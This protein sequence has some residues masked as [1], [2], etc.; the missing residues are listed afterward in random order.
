MT[1]VLDNLTGVAPGGRNAALNR[2]AWTLG[3]WVAAGA[4]DQAEVEDGLFDAAERNRLVADDGERQIW[5]TIRSGLSAGLLQP[6]DL[7]KEQ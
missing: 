3:R 1:Q 2:A 6:V 4:L 7:D 5:A